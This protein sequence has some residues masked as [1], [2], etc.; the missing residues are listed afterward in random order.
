[1]KDLVILMTGAGAPG[2][3][4]IIKSYRNN[5][6]R[7]V[8]IIG[9]DAKNLVPTV[10][11][12]DAFETVPM[13]SDDLFIDSILTVAKKYNVDV[14]QPLVTRELELFSEKIELFRNEGIGVCVSPIDNLII[15]N[16]KAKLIRALEAEGL[17]VPHYYV[18]K[19]IES[20]IRACEKLGYPNEVICFKP[21]KA[22]GSRGFRI[23]DN[24]IDRKKILFEMKPNSTYITYDE[25]VDILSKGDFPELLVM[26]FMPGEEYSVDMLV[27]HG[28]VKYA[29]PRLRNVMNGG[30]STDCTVVN[31]K[32]VIEYAE[33]VGKCLKLHG[34]I[35]VQVRRAS[36][37]RPKILEINPRVQGTI[38]CCSAAG[39]NMPYFGIKMALNEDIP[40]VVVKWNTRMIRHW[41]ECY[42]DAYGQS[43]TY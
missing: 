6:E 4:G 26:E 11:M 5:G 36:D 22:N 9:V 29:I 12:L 20:F 17:A 27:D 21:S 43:Y 14:I 31:S 40:K 3:P 25:A 39:V 24:T 16:D 19:D 41:D 32:D 35:G 34:N 28:E 33:R 8:K 18:V 2:A 10:N 1:M 30:I 42:Y 38:V 15:A 23:I 13:A 7:N 37:G